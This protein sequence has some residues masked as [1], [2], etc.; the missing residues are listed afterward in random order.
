MG[1]DAKS[2]F[3]DGL[4]AILAGN[5]EDTKVLQLAADL[6]LSKVGGDA[7]I[8]QGGRGYWPRLCNPKTN[9]T[10]DYSP[11]NLRDNAGKGKLAELI[12]SELDEASRAALAL[13]LDLSWTAKVQ[14]GK[15]YEADKAKAR[16]KEGTIFFIESF[17][18]PDKRQSE[19]LA[20]HPEA[21]EKVTSFL[22]I[23]DSLENP[24][25]PRNRKAAPALVYSTLLFKFFPSPVTQ[26]LLALHIA[27]PR[28]KKTAALASDSFASLGDDPIKLARGERGY[29]FP[30][31]T[32]LPLFGAA[33]T[34][35]IRWS[36]FDIAAF[37]EALKTVN[38]FRLKTEERLE[39]RMK[40]ET[41]ISYM[42]GE[43]DKWE[44]PDEAEESEPPARI[45]DD[46]RVPLVAKLLDDRVKDLELTDEDSPSR[47]LSPRRLRGWT[48]LAEKFT[49]IVEISEPYSIAKYQK[50]KKAL[51]EYQTEHK[52]D[53]GDAGLFEALIQKA[54]YWCL[55]QKPNDSQLQERESRGWSDN[56]LATYRDYLEFN[57]EIQWL[58]EPIRFTPA[59]ARESRRLF[60]FSDLS[61]RSKIKHHA[62]TLAV[63]VSLALKENDIWKE[64]RALLPYSAPRLRRD[65]LRGEEG[66]DDLTETPWMQPM[67]EALGL[68]DEWKQDVSGHAVS[69]MPEPGKN[70]TRYLLNFP[71]SLEPSKLVA[72]V[73]KENLW[74]GQF[75]GTRDKHIHLHW[76]TTMDEKY[77]A[78]AWWRRKEPFTCLAADLGTRACAAVAVMEFLPGKPGEHERL[79]GYAEGG[80]WKA[81][82][83]NQDRELLR[84]PGED[85]RVLEKGR[86]I[87]EPYGSKGREPDVEETAEFDRWLR[88]FEIK[89]DDYL[90]DQTSGLSFPQQNDRL[91]RIFRRGQSRNM[92][93]NRWLRFLIEGDIKRVEETLAAIQEEAHVD[94]KKWAKDNS[95]EPLKEALRVEIIRHQEILK[96]EIEILANRILPLRG[97]R[98]K[99]IERPDGKNWVLQ[100]TLPGTDTE[101]KKIRGQRGMSVWRIEQV[102]ELRRRLQSLNR[103]LQRKPGDK[104]KMGKHSL[105]S[106]LPDPCPDIAEKLDALKEQRINQTS[107]LILAKALGVR[108]KPHALP[109]FERKKRDVHG[110]YELIPDRKPV[111]FIVLEDLSRYRTSQD[112][113]P[114]EN[115]RLMKWCHRAITEKLKQLC[116]PY[117]I[118]VLET[119]AAYT[120]KFCSR[121]GIAG[122]RARE[123]K[124]GQ[125]HLIGKKQREH[126]EFSKLES[127]LKEIARSGR[128]E[129]P[130][131]VPARGG[132]LFV[133]AHQFHELHPKEIHEDA[134]L[135]AACNLALRAVA[136]PD[137]HEI[138]TRMR[139]KKEKG[140]LKF[141]GSI[142][143]PKPSKR[144]AARFET[145]MEF[146]LKDLAAEDP[147][148]DNENEENSHISNVFVD[149]G[150]VACFEGVQASGWD[151][152]LATGKGLW[153]TIKQWEFTYCNKLNQARIEK[154]RKEGKLPP[155]KDDDPIPFD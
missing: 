4:R 27:K 128:N 48:Q 50:L 37:K 95:M 38:Q 137:A 148:N 18:N 11:Q 12:H 103:A 28:E 3:E 135:N 122:F 126:F 138:L 116:E 32:S 123:I 6:L 110:E 144:D 96:R 102:E 87:Q 47:T 88:L 101:K 119:P 72:L 73:G 153:G 10:W 100:Q 36:E 108:L 140:V 60:M 121:T 35:D 63:E 78:E 124:P 106:E 117:G 130:L 81:C 93:L 29:V 147:A 24:I 99:W 5:K 51:T 71:I 44:D 54:E 26:A 8:Q 53:M 43:H 31:F 42:R 94:W 70:G 115:S 52:D 58:K 136:A 67:M 146:H 65:H 30:A 113:G 91:L 112:R 34:E 114:S 19:F 111:D 23:I 151:M 131:I 39:R 2:N 84:L 120:S 133:T 21:Q 92:Q 145:A 141:A 134:D 149:L 49:R 46:P 97:R 25:L 80:P 57:E 90:R 40:Y 155:H 62:D 76:P 15:F 89:E 16:L 142:K 45:K 69:L 59:D 22:G 74:K 17:K 83:L 33:N 105:G 20:M 61:G 86:W 75:N 154:W 82:L 77:L 56:I 107:H 1:L 109:D 79:V 132:P 68:E 127:M 104:A 125:T 129:L 150:K 7:A 14:P 98:W 139:C 118:P 64:R 143:N 152:P 85:V 9:P 66:S 13:E 41:A 55:W